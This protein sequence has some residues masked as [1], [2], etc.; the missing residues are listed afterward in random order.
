MKIYLDYIFIENFIIDFI[1]LYETSL[2]AKIKVKN[3][4]LVIAAALSSLYVV[5]MIVFKL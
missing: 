1:I 2:M 4:W 5:I 3:K